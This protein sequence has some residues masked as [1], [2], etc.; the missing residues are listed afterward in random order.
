MRKPENIHTIIET[1]EVQLFNPGVTRG[2]AMRH[3]RSKLGITVRSKRCYLVPVA[4]RAEYE[5][6]TAEILRERI[7]AKVHNIET[8]GEQYLPKVAFALESVCF[9]FG[10]GQRRQ[11]QRRDDRDNSYHDQQLNERKAYRFSIRRYNIL[12]MSSLDEWASQIGANSV[13]VNPGSVP[14]SRVSPTLFSLVVPQRVS[15]RS[16]DK[17]SNYHHQKHSKLECVTVFY[18]HQ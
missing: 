12:S 18:H 10:R 2:R 9:A 7:A 16:K 6:P 8:L 3:I 1:D 13:K 14:Q 4:I 11:Q 15:C 17:Q 5:R